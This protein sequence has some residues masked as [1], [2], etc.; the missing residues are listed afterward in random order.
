[1]RSTAQQPANHQQQQEQQ[2]PVQPAAAAL[3]CNSPGSQH[4][5]PTAEAAADVDTSLGSFELLEGAAPDQLAAVRSRAAPPPLSLEE[6]ASF[7]D[8]G[9]VMVDEAGFRQRVFQAGEGL[10]RV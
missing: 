6:L 10:A 7:L 1:M 5:N 9:G 4:K 2:L 8:S 3:S